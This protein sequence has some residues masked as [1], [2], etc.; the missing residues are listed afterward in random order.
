MGTSQFGE[1]DD[2]HKPLTLL[3]RVF[4]VVL[5]HEEVGEI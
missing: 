4:C 1:H 5:T 2:D 3:Q